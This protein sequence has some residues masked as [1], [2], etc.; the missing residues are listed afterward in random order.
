MDCC[1]DAVRR[2]LGPHRAL[3]WSRETQLLGELLYYTLTTGGGLQTLGE[4]YCDVLQA[5][6]GAGLAPGT[7]R[8]GTLVLLQTLAPYLAE[9]V[10]L[11]QDEGFAAWQASRLQQQREQQHS[12][13]Q[14]QQ[15]QRE[16][17]GAR[18][19]ASLQQW[20][21][22]RSY[23]EGTAARLRAQTAQLLAPLSPACRTAARWASTNGAA[24]LRVHLALFYIYGAYF[25]V[26]KRLTGGCGAVFSGRARERMQQ[27]QYWGMQEQKNW[28]PI[29]RVFFLRPQ[30]SIP[31][32]MLYRRR[33]S[34][35]LPGEAV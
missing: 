32:P 18:Q 27:L 16:G 21:A 17:Q 29:A 7:L 33:G 23:V 1:Y 28:S 22:A 14:R 26:S 12:E 13:Q 3:L 35:S 9:R 2:L 24:A 8:R 11:Q 5:T 25:Q 30:L 34:L 31:S 6:G 4:E 20:H 15:Q 19:P 10:A